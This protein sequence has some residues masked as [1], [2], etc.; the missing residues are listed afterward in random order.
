MITSTTGSSQ[1]LIER[2]GR[3]GRR[4]TSWVQLAATVG[5]HNSQMQPAGTQPQR[6]NIRIFIMLMHKFAIL[7]LPRERLF[8]L[9]E[10]TTGSYRDSFGVWVWLGLRACQK[11]HC[12]VS[13]PLQCKDAQTFK[14]HFAQTTQTLYSTQN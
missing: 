8:L 12:P 6:G 7:E 2:L 9:S 5:Q 14:N 3:V 4:Q 10:K 13:W 11:Y 1:H